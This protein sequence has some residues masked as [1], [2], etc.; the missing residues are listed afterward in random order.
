MGLDEIN[1]VSVTTSLA[2]LGLIA[3][4]YDKIVIEMRIANLIKLGEVIKDENA[5]TQILNRAYSLMEG[6]RDD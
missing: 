4:A 3:E 5:S 6:K 2:K 1:P